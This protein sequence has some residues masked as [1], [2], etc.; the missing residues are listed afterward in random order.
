MN[1][2]IKYL[3]CISHNQLLELYLFPAHG[4]L[5][6]YTLVNQRSKIWDEFFFILGP[7]TVQEAPSCFAVYQL[8]I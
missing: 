1:H 3:H 6:N 4:L 7:E 2:I 5:S 8:Y